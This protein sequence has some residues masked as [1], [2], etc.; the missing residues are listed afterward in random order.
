MIE[1]EVENL[2]L[3]ARNLK[4]KI[5]DEI[6]EKILKLYEIHKILNNKSDFYLYYMYDVKSCGSLNFEINYYTY[7]ETVNLRIFKDKSNPICDVVEFKKNLK[8]VSIKNRYHLI[9]TY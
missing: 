5:A 3:K 1:P 4:I 2:L 6:S 7:G 8:I 9:F